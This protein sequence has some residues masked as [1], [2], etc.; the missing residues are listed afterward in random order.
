MLQKLANYAA[1]ITSEGF[2][3]QFGGPTLQNTTIVVHI[4]S[5]S[6]HEVF[7]LLE[8]WRPNAW[9]VNAGFRVET[10]QAAEPPSPDS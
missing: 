1:F 2:A 5:G 10:V 9:A 3:E 7:Q 6:A 4:H 8:A